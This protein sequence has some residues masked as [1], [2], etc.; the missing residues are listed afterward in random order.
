MSQNVTVT[1]YITVIHI[2]PGVHCGPH[3][4]GPLQANGNRVGVKEKKRKK[5]GLI[6]FKRYLQYNNLYI[7]KAKIFSGGLR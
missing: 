4:W 2:K 6:D 7:L 5:R 3:I 1:T